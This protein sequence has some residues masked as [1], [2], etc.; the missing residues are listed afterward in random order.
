MAR[1]RGRTRVAPPRSGPAGVPPRLSAA[2]ARN[3]SRSTTRRWRRHAGNVRQSTLASAL[4]ARAV[5]RRAG[6]GGP[7]GFG[8]IDLGKKERPQANIVAAAHP[9][10]HRQD[11]DKDFLSGGEVELDKLVGIGNAVAVH[12]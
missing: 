10:A 2:T 3:S 11:F 8:R 9:F 1:N 5:K 4:S 12:G 7:S 6:D